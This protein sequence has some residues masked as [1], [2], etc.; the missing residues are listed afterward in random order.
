MPEKP[1]KLAPLK[2]KKSKS[3]TLSENKIIHENDQPIPD[4]NSVDYKELSEDIFSPDTLPESTERD[5]IRDK[6]K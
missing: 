5:T 2:S 6:K 3:A 4:P 1:N